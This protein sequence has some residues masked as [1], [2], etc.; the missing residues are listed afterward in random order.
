MTLRNGEVNHVLAQIVILFYLI[1][2]N[3]ILSISNNLC[4]TIIFF[5]LGDSTKA[6]SCALG[7]SCALGKGCSCCVA[8]NGPS[9]DDEDDDTS[10]L[11]PP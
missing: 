1:L 11:P 10:P 5:D 2:L 7:R 3:F 8:G 9:D 6:G 4:L